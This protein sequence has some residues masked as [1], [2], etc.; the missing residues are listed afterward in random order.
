MGEALLHANHVRNLSPMT[1]LSCT[2]FEK[3]FG[4]KP[5]LSYLRIFGCEC[6]VFLP[7][8]KREGKFG[9]VSVPGI[10]LGYQN[11]SYRVLIDDRV[12]ICRAADVRVLEAVTPL[13]QTLPDLVQPPVEFP[14]PLGSSP[15]L[16]EDVDLWSC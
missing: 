12:R 3:M 5:D 8:H 10:F 2:P 6:Y 15:S 16:V 9:P 11:K 7:K 1:G 4:R 13:S 14:T